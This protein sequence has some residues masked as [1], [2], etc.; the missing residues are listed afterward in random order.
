[1][2]SN[3]YRIMYY[4]DKEKTNRVTYFEF[5]WNVI[6]FFF[7]QIRRQIARKISKGIKMPFTGMIKFIHIDIKPWNQ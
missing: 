1:M 3:G 6:V 4:D 7:K 2:F 5:I